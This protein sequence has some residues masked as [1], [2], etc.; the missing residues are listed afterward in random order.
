MRI[1]VYGGSFNPPHLGHVEAAK[2][3]CRQL[4]PDKLYIIPTSTPP[5]KELEADSPDGEERLCLCRLAFA[6]IPCAEFSDMEIKRGG[7]SYTSDTLDALRQQFPDAE[8]FLVVGTDM[9]L[10]FRTWH[11]YQHIFTLCTVCVLARESDDRDEICDFAAELEQEGARVRILRHEPLEMSSTEIRE[12]LRMGLGCDMLPDAVYR[13]I[14]RLRHYGAEPELPWLREQALDYLS[15]NRVAHTAGCESEAVQ[16]AM[17]WGENPER[18]AVAGILHDVTKKPD[19]DTQL[20]LCEKYGIILD[21]TEK[22]SPQLLH[23][24]TGAALAKDEFGVPDDVADAIRWHTT[25]KPDMTLLEKI[26]YLADIIEPNRDY[27][28]VEEL[29]ELAYEDIDRAMGRALEISLESIRRRNIVPHTDTIE[30]CLW[31]NRPE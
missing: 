15:P 30:A 17:R 3:V 27:E 12:K 7:R 18:A 26:I 24:R 31:Y 29:R 9:F 23:A 22:H 16:L 11:C 4:S 13:R 10:S 2:S 28:G 25:G 14:I 6:D 1:A 8:L 19:F 5:H 20:K 21:E